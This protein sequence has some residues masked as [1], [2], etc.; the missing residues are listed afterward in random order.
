MK[1]LREKDEGGKPTGDPI[2][3]WGCSGEHSLH[4][5]TAT[6]DADKKSIVRK[7][8]ADAAKRDSGK[9]QTNKVLRTEQPGGGSCSARIPSVALPDAVPT[10]L[11][12]GCDACAVI[13]AGLHDSIKQLSKL[14]LRPARPDQ[15]WTLEG[16]G[17]APVPMDLHVVLPTLEL[18][19][20]T[21]TLRLTNV[22]AWVDT[23]DKGLNITLGRP[24]MVAMGYSTEGLLAA[25]REQGDSVDL[26]MLSVT[27]A[28]GS[29]EV[30][31]TLQMRYAERL[32]QQEDPDVEDDDEAP[33]VDADKA[34]Q[35]VAEVLADKFKEAKA[36]GLKGRPLAKLKHLLH[37][38]R[39]VFRLAFKKTDQP[40]KVEPLQV[41][42]REDAQPRVCKNRRYS[43]DEQA[44]L[45]SHLDSIIA[46]DL[47]RRNT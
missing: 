27:A 45:R 43:P 6:S 40:I 39:D 38:F 31:K 13:S 36:K 47:G 35:L 5:C 18:D 7:R 30:Y 16:F 29:E 33:E 12:S 26:S 20:P 15:A 23:T 25:V 10:L 44:F 11:D 21:G 32:S 14:D 24:V 9:R 46:N 17:G 42:L 22:N 8:R 3:C 4:E 41:K 2:K 1:T 28:T 34:D 37:R 19:T